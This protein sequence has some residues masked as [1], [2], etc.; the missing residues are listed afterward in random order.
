MVIRILDIVRGADTAK[1]GSLVY[2][3]LRTALEKGGSVSVSFDGLD[4]A[5]P[6]LSLQL[7]F[8]RF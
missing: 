6:P 1:Q 7:H 4:I 8:Y 5:Q 3:Q 2:I